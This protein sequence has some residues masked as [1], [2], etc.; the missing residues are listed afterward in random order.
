MDTPV[1]L[2]VFN[3]PDTTAKL[4]ASLAAVRPARLFVTADGPRPDRPGEAER[5]RATRALFEHLPW[6]CTLETLYSEQNL[7]L[8][9][10]VV[11]A[12][13]WFFACNPA[14]IVLEDD[15]IP[16]PTFFTYCTELLERYRDDERLMLISGVN[17]QGGARR[18]PHSYFFSQLIHIWGWATW[19]R[20][21]KH[22]DVSMSTWPETRRLGLLE[23]MFPHP[24][25]QRFWD[26]KLRGMAAGRK[27]SW[28]Y[29]WMYACYAQRGLCILPETNLITNIGGEFGST[30]QSSRG[31]PFLD[32]PHKAMTFPLSH[33]PHVM[34]N[35]AAERHTQA[36]LRP[37][38]WQ[39]ALRRFLGR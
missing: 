21:W 7:G 24:K 28:A 37:S 35:P 1:L 13:N 16:H 8:Q 2:I 33:P 4:L 15:C 19:A 11:S 5:C 25:A 38:R 27:D 30:H 31:D 34:V 9:Q 18:T 39:R 20:A 6:P 22:F 23:Q 14:G 10:R 17:F 29:A 32:I 26:G 3:R 36:L 12:M